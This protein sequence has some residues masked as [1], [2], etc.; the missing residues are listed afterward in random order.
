M[1][2]ERLQLGGPH[3]PGVPH[4]V[5]PHIAPHPMDVLLLCA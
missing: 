2:E 1:R 3:V 4:A 5:M